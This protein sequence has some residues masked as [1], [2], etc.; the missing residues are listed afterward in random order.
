MTSDKTGKKL[1]L[2]LERIGV[3]ERIAAQRPH[4]TQK[5]LD[6]ILDAV[7]SAT[8]HFH[9]DGWNILVELLGHVLGLTVSRHQKLLQKLNGE[10]QEYCRNAIEEPWDYLGALFVDRRL[11]GPGQNLTSRPIVEF[12]IKALFAE[13]KKID[14]AQTVLDPAVGTGRFLIGA[15]ILLP[16]IPLILYGIEVDLSLYRAC[17]VNLKMFSSHPFHIVCADTLMLD[18]VWCGPA[19]PMWFLA[20]RWNPPDMTPWYWKPPPINPKSFSLK[21]FTEKRDK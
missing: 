1:D 9:R 16:D 20:N 19:S 5:L 12:M 2:L 14:R 10:L 11:E 21:A 15:T 17:L 7:C 18:Q 13:D 8:G 3:Y 6:E 4:K